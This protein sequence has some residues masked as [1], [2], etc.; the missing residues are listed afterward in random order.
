MPESLINTKRRINTIKSTEKITKAMKLVA[1][2][3]YQR[4]KKYYDD[5][6]P[7]YNG[8]KETLVKAIN[9]VDFSE[10]QKSEAVKEHL[11]GKTLYILVTS[12]LGLCGSYNYSLF[13]TLDPLLKPNDEF[14][15]IGSKGPLH[16]KD[17]GYES[18][19]DY[20]ST[21]DS[22]SYS[23]V[24][25]LRHLLLQK[26]R[27]G[28]YEKVVLVYTHYKNSM[29]FLPTVEQIL[30]LDNDY[31]GVNQETTSSTFSPIYEPDSKTVLDNLIPHYIDSLLY[32]RLIESELSELAS[33][34]NAMEA[35]TDSADKIVKQLTIVYNKSRQN[36]ITQEITE[37]VGGA[38]AGKENEN[39]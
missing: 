29:T 25:R 11:G 1:S 7:Y 6:K 33:R 34:R 22:F 17:K 4:W 12:S 32:N 18:N 30:P 31:L 3:K 8:L 9:G 16:Y 35:A 39:K 10:F 20:V 23:K 38:N 5:N 36:A 14:I 19:E 2:V 28:D 15:F 26:Y 24:R 13:K 27:T 37:V 21:L